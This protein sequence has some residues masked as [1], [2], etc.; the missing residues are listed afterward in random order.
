MQV[1]EPWYIAFKWTSHGEQELPVFNL[2]LSGYISGSTFCK[3]SQQSGRCMCLLMMT[4][5]AYNK[6]VFLCHCQQ[7]DLNTCAVQL[8]TRDRLSHMMCKQ[9]L[10]RQPV[11]NLFS[12]WTSL[13]VKE[14]ITDKLNCTHSFTFSF[15]VSKNVLILESAQFKHLFK[16]KYPILKERFVLCISNRIIR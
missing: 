4:D 3:H 16:S 9:S 14:N 12:L 10:F 5:D 6:F 2:T 1:A 7:Q 15:L 11:I 13:L 8:H